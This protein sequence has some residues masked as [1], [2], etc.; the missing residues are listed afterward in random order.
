MHGKIAIVTGGASGIG[1]AVAEALGRRGATVI[2]ADI[3]AAH[4][5][6]VARGIVEAAGKADSAAVDVSDAAAVQKLVDDAVTRHGRLDYMFNNAGVSMACEMRDTTLE[7]WDRIVRVNLHGVIN[8]VQAA[9]AQMLRQGH[10]HIVNTG[11]IAGLA[12]FPL[13]VVYNTTKHAVVG[14]STSLRSEAAGL[15]VKVSVVCPGF[16]DTPMKDR[17]TY[18]NL[19]REASMRALPFKLYSA[20]A[21]AADILRGVER[22]QAVIL[23]PLHARLLW[24]LHRLAPGVFI[25]ANTQ[26]A[27]Q[28]RKLRTGERRA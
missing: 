25:W 5:S 14:L 19:D 26:A 13:T 23:A 9:Y 11:S 12:P 27:K 16:I 4:A 1:R 28:I 15:G 18:R 21:C 24:W 3:N 2:V 20:D 6:D 22:N 8:G 7:D 10:G 17:L